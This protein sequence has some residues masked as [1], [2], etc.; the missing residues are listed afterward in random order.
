MGKHISNSRVVSHFGNFGVKSQWC[1]THVPLVLGG[2]A[3]KW[4]AQQ[5]DAHLNL[6][7]STELSGGRKTGDFQRLVVKHASRYNDATILEGWLAFAH[8]T[9]GALLEVRLIYWRHVAGG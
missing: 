9:D 8:A 7:L 5:A 6:I 3:Q 2:N 1:C 4:E